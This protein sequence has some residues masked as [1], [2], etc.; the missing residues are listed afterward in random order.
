MLIIRGVSFYYA[1]DQSG[2][3]N[4]DGSGFPYHERLHLKKFRG[5]DFKGSTFVAKTTTLERRRGKAY[6]EPGN[7]ALEK[8]GMTPAE[9]LPG[10]IHV[11]VRSWLRGAALNAVGLSGPGIAALLE[12]GIWHNQQRP[13]QISLMSLASTSEERLD[14]LSK[15]VELIK[16]HLPFRSKFGIQLNISCPNVE[17]EEDVAKVVAETRDSLAILRLLGEDVTLMVKIDALFPVWAAVE[18]AADPNLDAFCNSNTI[19]WKYLPEDVRHRL[20]GTNVSPLEKFGGGGISGAYLFPLVERWV[21]EARAAGIT[22]PIIAGGGILKVR[23]VDRL[24][25]AGAS[26]IAVGSV[27]FL[28]P[29]RVQ[30]IIRRANVLGESGRMYEPPVMAV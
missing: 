14:A 8:D 19:H 30:K 1:F 15:M 5:F 25:F 16:P 26:A 20:F 6:G 3:R 23:D 29:W 13:F 11:S 21:R 10:C 27:A 4:F 17:H 28:R 24:A 7:M 22:K 9:L 12:K 18:M 2:V